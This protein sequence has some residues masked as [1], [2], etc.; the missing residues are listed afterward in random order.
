MAATI[1][2]IIL[3]AQSKAAEAAD[4]PAPLPAIVFVPTAEPLGGE[5]Q[6][7][8]LLAAGHQAEAEALL[9]A[10]IAAFPQ[11]AATGRIGD[12][13]QVDRSR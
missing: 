12:P 2:S 11:D 4:K 9:E 8:Q 5:R 6:V 7:L 3:L 10:Q 13:R 1:A